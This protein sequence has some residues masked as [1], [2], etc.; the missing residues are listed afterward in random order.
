[1]PFTIDGT[2][3]A[4]SG[5][6]RVQLEVRDRDTQPVPAGQPHHLGC[7]R[8]RSTPTLGH[9]E[10]GDHQ[11]VADAD[12]PA[13]PPTPDLGPDLRVNGTSDPSK[14]LKRIET[15]GLADETPTTTVT[16]PVGQR[17][18]DDDVHRHRHGRGRPRRQRRSRS[19]CVTCRTA[20][21]RTTAAPPPPTTRFRGVPDVVGATSATW[22]YEVTVPYEG[23]W[24]MQAIAVDTSGQSD[25]RS[26]DR[27]WIV[28]DT[29]IA[30][31]VTITTPG[32]DDPADG[33]ADPHAWPP[34]ARSPSRALPPTTRASTTSTIY[35]AQQLDPR[36]PVGRRHV[37]QSTRSPVATGSR[38]QN[39]L[40]GT[41]YNW[42]YTT[43][44]NLS[45][46]IYTLHRCGAIDDLG[47]STSSSNQG[48]LTINVQVPGDAFPNTTIT[49]DGTQ[50]RPAGAAPR[51]RRF[52]NRRHRRRVRPGDRPRPR[53]QPLPAAQRH[54]GGRLH[55]AAT[56]PS[57]T[58]ARPAR[59]GRCRSTCR[60]RAT[61]R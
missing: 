19:P 24:T 57:P 42:S 6:Q 16:G 12:H 36:E 53:H 11:L 14:A 1:M 2:A 61:T 39:S 5:V 13:E 46:G 55:A 21:S 56:P 4:T 28:S 52:G 58:R 48:R 25:L 54:P 7:A 9:A 22:S 30:P 51:P 33:R 8:T 37:G 29:A 17:H 45:P 18:P 15:F 34:A 10:R 38:G 26:A 3:R 49:P 47:L 20:T 43:P 40:P 35:A 60:P 44:F 50:S 23:E 27:T 32:V 41:T 59:R 31:T